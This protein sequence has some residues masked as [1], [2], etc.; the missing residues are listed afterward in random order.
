MVT[1]LRVAT[2]ALHLNLVSSSISFHTLTFSH[3]RHATPSPAAKMDRTP[4]LPTLFHTKEYTDCTL[5]ASN[6]VEFAAHR[7]VVAQYAGLKEQLAELTG[8][9]IQLSE[10]A[11]VVDRMLQWMYNIPWPTIEEDN[12]ELVAQDL[13]LVMA[14]VDAATKVSPHSAGLWQQRST[15]VLCE[16]YEIPKLALDMWEVVG[17][18]IA[19]V[20]STEGGLRLLRD[21]F[22]GPAVGALQRMIID[23]ALELL[24][25]ANIANEA[26]PANANIVRSRKAGNVSAQPD[27]DRSKTA[28]RL[29]IK[30]SKKA[31]RME[32][33]L[34]VVKV[35]K[36]PARERKLSKKAKA[37]VISSH[38]WNNL[39]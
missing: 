33:Y 39:S 10:P 5:I 29:V 35:P 4:D 16:Q 15:D 38:Y 1:Q 24:P 2:N 22:Q 28:H 19:S 9:R 31:G 17:A 23:R 27:E 30:G 3:H 34:Q 18:R 8:F 11:N 32:G 20:T 21:I 14:A 37:Y 12:S 7:I 25:P 13:L 26:I 36:T 6:G